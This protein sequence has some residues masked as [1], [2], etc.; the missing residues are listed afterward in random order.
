MGRFE[1][2]LENT[3]NL[4]L[5]MDELRKECEYATG[6]MASKLET[7]SDTAQFIQ[8]ATTKARKMA[9]EKSMTQDDETTDSNIKTTKTMKAPNGRVVVMKKP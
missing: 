4:N 5:N 8:C 1:R 3:N 2:F 6:I 9:G 7:C